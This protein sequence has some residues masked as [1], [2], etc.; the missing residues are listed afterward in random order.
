MP[1]STIPKLV[2][3]SR[4][5]AGSQPKRLCN[6]LYPYGK[7]T[8]RNS[9]YHVCRSTNSLFY[10]NIANAIQTAHST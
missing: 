6:S 1:N 8:S 9:G 7:R 4:P 10:M 3:I 2:A 5:N